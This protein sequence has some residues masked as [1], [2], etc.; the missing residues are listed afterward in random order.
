MGLLTHHNPLD[1]IYICDV[2]FEDEQ[3]SEGQT[4]V[5]FCDAKVNLTTA[6]IETALYETAQNCVKQLLHQG[7]GGAAVSVEIA[8][9]QSATFAVEINNEQAKALGEIHR[10]AFETG[11]I[12]DY[13]KKYPS[14]IIKLGESKR[15]ELKREYEQRQR[16]FAILATPELMK[17]LAA[18]PDAPIY[19][20]V[21]TNKVDIVEPAIIVRRLPPNEQTRL[22]M[23]RVL[24]LDYEGDFA[25]YRIPIE[26]LDDA[27]KELERLITTTNTSGVIAFAKHSDGFALAW[28]DIRKPQK[29]ELDMM[30]QQYEETGHSMKP[31]PL[32]VQAILVKA[33][34]WYLWKIEE[35]SK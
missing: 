30:I 6:I 23:Q 24:I 28:M 20:E 9:G 5:L 21:A 1:R 22:G 4:G 17:H 34:T 25:I 7:K 27:E 10:L 32:E 14:E 26:A 19:L 16:G 35:L 3:L 8:P 18:S 11:V 33:Q 2:Q 13:L 29:E 12:P 31:M 15:K